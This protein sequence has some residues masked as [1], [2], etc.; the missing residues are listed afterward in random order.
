MMLPHHEGA[1]TMSR[2]ELAKGKDAGLLRLA[3]QI[4][5]AQQREISA[6]RRQLAKHGAAPMDEMDAA[7]GSG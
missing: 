5:T 7:H 4:I 1:I 2:A 3:R 6:M